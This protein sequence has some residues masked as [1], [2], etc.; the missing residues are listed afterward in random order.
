MNNQ[1]KWTQLHG[2]SKHQPIYPHDIYIKCVFKNFKK[3][4]KILD[5]GCGAG[6]H[7]KFLAENNYITYG[8]DY[9][10]SGVKHT[11]E[12]LNQYNLKAQVE[13]AN[14]NELPYENEFFDGIL[15]WGVLYYNNK[16]VIEK[17]ACEIYRVLKQDGK[18]FV[19]TRNLN[20][21]RYK[22]GV[23][24]NDKYSI[25]I[26]ENNPKR[27]AYAENGMNMYFFDKEEVKRVFS[28]FNN[29]EINTLEIYH[30]NNNI[31]D[32][33]YVILLEK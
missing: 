16:E 20:D 30:E 11:K 19:L 3:E 31:C 15:C 26:Q 14:V 10:H 22:H 18:A 4:S 25:T 12:L 21:Y 27:S 13:L 17:A 28:M 8:C 32:S 29:I 23:K 1:E 2:N 33:D 7:V 9:S 24:N 6:R 5:L